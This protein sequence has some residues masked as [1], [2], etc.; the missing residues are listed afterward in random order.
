MQ[1]SLGIMLRRAVE[2]VVCVAQFSLVPHLI[3]IQCLGHGLE[4]AATKNHERQV[5]GSNKTIYSHFYTVNY[6][7]GEI[8]FD[9]IN[10]QCLGH[11]LE[12]AATKNL[13]RMRKGRGALARHG[14]WALC[15]DWLLNLLFVLLWFHLLNK[16]RNT[17]ISLSTA[18]DK[19][20]LSQWKE[21]GGGL[22]TD[23]AAVMVVRAWGG[24]NTFGPKLPT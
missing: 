21:K 7:V 22:S 18:L 6:H 12:L 9:M 1:Q 10:I 20:D 11:V 24:H 13:E 8:T 16:S 14:A 17:S 19:A 15:C 2:S 3:N 23:G 5:T 4:L